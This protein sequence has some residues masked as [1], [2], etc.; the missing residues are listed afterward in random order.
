MFLVK[1]IS[2]HASCKYAYRH[3]TKDRR[4]PVIDY[5]DL[6][7]SE[8]EGSAFDWVA[9]VISGTRSRWIPRAT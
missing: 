5:L 7:T 1:P 3:L 6:G 8:R 9:A 2:N 4:S